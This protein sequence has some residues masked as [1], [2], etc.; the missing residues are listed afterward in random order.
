MVLPSL[1]KNIFS[2][3]F[4]HAFLKFTPYTIYCRLENLQG[5]YIL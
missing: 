4:V 5:G 1:F 3:H 2:L